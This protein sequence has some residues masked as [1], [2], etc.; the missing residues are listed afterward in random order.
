MTAEGSGQGAVPDAALGP[1]QEI[2]HAWDEAHAEITRKPLSHFRRAV[3]IQFDELESHLAAGDRDAA[4]REAVDVISI[5]L[6]TLRWLNYKPEE[7]E[8]LVRKRAERRMKGQALAILDK[9]WRVYD[10]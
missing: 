6:N 2:W 10:I 1:F 7:I 5:A 9:Y 8:D 3:D 4:A